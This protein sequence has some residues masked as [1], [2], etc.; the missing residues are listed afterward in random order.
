MNYFILMGCLLADIQ[1]DTTH[2]DAERPDIVTE[3]PPP[4][5]R[6]PLMMNGLPITPEVLTIGFRELA[7]PIAVYLGSVAIVSYL[8]FF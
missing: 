2:I 7:I 4:N 5:E 1:A 3:L 6:T 8:A